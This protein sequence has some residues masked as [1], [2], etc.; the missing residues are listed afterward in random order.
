VVAGVVALVGFSPD[1][2]GGPA[3]A[4]AAALAKFACPGPSEDAE[5]GPETLIDCDRVAKMFSL[6]VEPA[7]KGPLM[8]ADRP[9]MSPNEVTTLSG[10]PGK[11]PPE[12]VAVFWRT[13]RGF[14]E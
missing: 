11:P 1:D 4:A 10:C 12:E 14:F 13:P 2:D 8:L 7:E 9:G 5:N 6:G 3:E